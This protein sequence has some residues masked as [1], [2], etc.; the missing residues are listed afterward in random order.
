MLYVD[1]DL[2]S[3]TV[4]MEHVKDDLEYSE[5]GGVYVSTGKLG[6]WKL[7]TNDSDL[8]PL[9]EKADCGDHLD[10]YVDNVI[11]INVEPA[12]QMQPH[13]V[14]RPRHNLLAGLYSN[15]FFLNIGLYLVIIIVYI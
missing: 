13:V 2:F 15:T 1:A 4:L 9:V 7:V 8:S 3:Y 6:N 10:F 5:I 14:I 11:D 12:K